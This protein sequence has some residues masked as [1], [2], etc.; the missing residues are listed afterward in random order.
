MTFA[1]LCLSDLVVC[2]TALRE[3]L[4]RHEACSIFVAGP[5]CARKGRGLAQQGFAVSRRCWPMTD[6]A[7]RRWR[8]T[9]ATV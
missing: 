9:C 8:T 6:L 5:T 7:R 1:S 3:G 2:C 4:G